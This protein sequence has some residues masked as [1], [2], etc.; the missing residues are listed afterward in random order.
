MYLHANTANVAKA[1]RD[2]KGELQLL[3]TKGEHEC[4][5]KRGVDEREM[6]ITN[7][8]PVTFGNLNRRAS[9]KAMLG[10]TGGCMRTLG[11]GY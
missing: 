3:P 9:W 8:A 5:A 2:M 11:T 10:M 6:E 7:A 4:K 1:K